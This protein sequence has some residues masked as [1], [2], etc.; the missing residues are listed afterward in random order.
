[1]AQRRGAEKV[2]VDARTV[3][4]DSSLHYD[5]C[6]VG[7]GPSGI[8]IARK[9]A[10]AGRRVALVEGGDFRPRIRDQQMF[11]GEVIG[12]PYYPLHNTRFRVVGGS[13]SRWGGICRPM[14]PLD[15][16]RR[17]WVDR[18]G[19]PMEYAEVA[20]LYPEAAEALAVDN[21]DFSHILPGASST[22]P[23]LDGTG[24]EEIYYR[25]SPLVDFGASSREALVRAADI[26]LLTNG[27]ATRVHSTP[28]GNQVTGI[29]VATFG[30]Q[31]FTVA[32]RTYVLA[33]GGIE[34]ARLLLVSNGVERAGLGNRHDVV[35]RYF[36][37]HVHVGVAT[38]TAE[39]PVTHWS[40]YRPNPPHQ[41]TLLSAVSL[42]ERVQTDERLLA[43]SV[44]IAPAWY[45]SRPPFVDWDARFTVP[46]ERLY[47]MVAARGSGRTAA[48]ALKAAR[49]VW[50]LRE[51]SAAT[52]D[53][54][55]RT[56]YYRGEQE[57]A[58]H[59]RVVLGD[60]R[61]RLGHP[62]ADLHWSVGE[63][64]FDNARAVLSRFAEGARLGGWGRVAGPADDWREHV[65]G[66]PHHMGTTRMSVDPRRGVV[67]PNGR[68]HGIA[69]LYVA[70]SSVFPTGGH[71]NPTL[72]V[73]A[74]NLRLAHHLLDGLG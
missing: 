3:P 69:N 55:A 44:T 47:R 70:G 73:T 50:N 2:L 46:A 4:A 13:G 26:T 63:R 53:H 65:V 19:W 30:G 58:A 23:D 66:G 68:V 36:M 71:A 57:P 7:A 12:S 35:G 72:T 24:F 51:G 20:K 25:S 1:M 43:A 49:K 59:N 6:I 45:S 22:A 56:V 52:H 27:N 38:L 11:G 5:I 18:S 62:L 21:G 40:S 14:D 29:E 16:R 15:F 41:P 61:D 42:S 54:R 32:A 48:S 33:A 74:L 31:A 64:E 17:D 8:T 34:N 60:R 28:E 37:E 10:A 9:L 67:D 39:A